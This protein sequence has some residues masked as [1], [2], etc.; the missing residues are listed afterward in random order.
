MRS[1]SSGGGE[2]AKRSGSRASRSHSRRSDS[3]ETRL[4]EASREPPSPRGEGLGVFRH[5]SYEPRPND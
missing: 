2:E 3:I 5:V 1:T 4:E